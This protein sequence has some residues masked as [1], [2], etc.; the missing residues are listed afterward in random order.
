M[1][2]GIFEKKFEGADKYLA[3]AAVDRLFLG[4]TCALSI[5]PYQIG[6]R[7]IGPLPDKGKFSD[8]VRAE[9][10]SFFSTRSECCLLRK[11][12]NQEL[13]GIQIASCQEFFAYLA[14]EIA[15]SRKRDQIRKLNGDDDLFTE[16]DEEYVDGYL[17]G[18][19]G[20]NSVVIVKKLPKQKRRDTL[21]WGL[22]CLLS[23]SSEIEAYYDYL[24]PILKF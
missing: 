2:W 9:A 16:I 10:L 17:V 21:D 14:I 13:S 4:E 12:W 8:E 3:Y 11:G 6:F 1:Y 5:K 24:L 7:L 20:C 18:L 23:D 19:R 22:R 15:I